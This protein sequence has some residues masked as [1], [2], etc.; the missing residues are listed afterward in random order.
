MNGW[1]ICHVVSCFLLTGS[2]VAGF[3]RK[4]KKHI[5]LWN[6]LSRTFSA[7]M[8]ISGIVMLISTDQTNLLN[9]L[10]KCALAIISIALIEIG[11]RKKKAG[12]LSKKF[13]LIIAGSM[14]LTIVCGYML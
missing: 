6:W 9:S 3:T 1:V 11:Y 10:I 2:I 7:S 4:E 12:T 8:L 5:V 14:L 13:I